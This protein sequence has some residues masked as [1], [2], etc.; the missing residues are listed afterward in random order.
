MS[1][2]LNFAWHWSPIT[3]IGLIVLCLL[4]AAG[5]RLTYKDNIQT[6]LKKR[7]I[8][9]FVAAIFV[10]ALILLTP[11]DTIA[12]TQLF[13]AHMIQ[14]VTVPTICAPLLLEAMPD[15]LVQSLVWRTPLRY[16]F[17]FL[18]FPVIASIIFNVTFLFWFV[19]S[20]YIYSLQH[21]TLYHVAMLCFLVTSLLNWWPLIGPLGRWRNLSYPAQMFYAFFDGQPVDIFAFLLVFTE[22]VI[23][24]GAGYHIPTSWLNYGYSPLADQTIGGA[25]LLVPGIV[26]L[27][28]M[29]PLFFRWLAQLEQKQ[30]IVDEQLQAELEEEEREEMQ[31]RLGI[32]V[33]HEQM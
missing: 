10:L 17:Q 20:V 15:W 24:S 19:P 12:R 31:G 16:V 28:V 14:A 2:S 18:T 1:N 4:Y 5:L 8:I 11:L 9:S 13:A 25:F 21:G 33:L 22:V 7:N 26:D 30:K 6:P 29:S 32:E 27:I 23:Y 3:S